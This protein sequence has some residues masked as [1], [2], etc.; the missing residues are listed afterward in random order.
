MMI[1]GGG[2]IIAGLVAGSFVSMGTVIVCELLGC[3]IIAAASWRTELREKQAARKLAAY[4]VYR[5]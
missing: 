4:P 5:Y 1:L 3:A 2:L